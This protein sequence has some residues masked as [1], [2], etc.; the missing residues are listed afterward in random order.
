MTQIIIAGVML[1]ISVTMIVYS[2]MPSRKEK[3]EH[4]LRRMQGTQPG[5]I[6]VEIKRVAKESAT[7]RMFD[8]VAPIAMK[9]VMPKSDE[10]MTTLRVK[11]ANAGIRRDNAAGLFDLK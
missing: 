7:Q 1:V 6:E 8:R 9:P 10:E 2:L 3:E 11:L 4:L 5:D